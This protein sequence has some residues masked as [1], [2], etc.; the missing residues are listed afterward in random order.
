MIMLLSKIIVNIIYGYKIIIS[1][2]LGKHCRF[3]P[4]CSQFAIEAI[5][6]FGL[7]KGIYFSIKR[8]IKCLPVNGGG[9][10]PI[11]KYL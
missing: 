4:S 2:L 3:I 5:V 9:Y 11:N 1:P 8:I 6:I 10:D 7:V